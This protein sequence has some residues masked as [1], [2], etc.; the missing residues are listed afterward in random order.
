M[1]YSILN[2]LYKSRYITESEK[3]K[4]IKIKTEFKAKEEEL[5]IKK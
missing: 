3:R 2:K 4:I 1:I 5:K